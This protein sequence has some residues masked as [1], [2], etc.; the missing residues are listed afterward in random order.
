MRRNISVGIFFLFSVWKIVMHGR[1]FLLGQKD[2][3][4]FSVGKMVILEKK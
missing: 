1:W 2:D 3:L 4:I